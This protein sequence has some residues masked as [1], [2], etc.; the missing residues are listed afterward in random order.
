MEQLTKE[1]I[2]ERFIYF[3]REFFENSLPMPSFEVS[4]TKARLGD[5]QVKYKNYRPI[6]RIRIT[7]FYN[8]DEN[9]CDT[10]IIHEMIHLWQAFNRT[11]DRGHGEDFKRKAKEIC[12]KSSAKY[13]ITRASR[14]PFQPRITTEGI[15]KEREYLLFKIHDKDLI[16]KFSPTRKYILQ[17]YLIDRHMPHEFKHLAIINHHLIPTLHKYLRGVEL[18]KLSTYKP[19]YNIF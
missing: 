7:N 6:Y 18:N 17:Q 13:K 9:Q 11:I 5:F 8:L 1:Y 16:C 14:G 10:T 2:Q 15:A 3:N 12:I 19:N 4:N